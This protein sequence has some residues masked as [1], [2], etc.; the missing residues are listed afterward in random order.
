MNENSEEAGWF[1]GRW[2]V[3][4]SLVLNTV[5]FMSLWDIPM[6]M[7]NKQLHL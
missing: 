3:I 7:I 2:G 1:G 6:K 4:K 5:F